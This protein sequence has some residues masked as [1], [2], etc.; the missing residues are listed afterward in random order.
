MEDFA[1]DVVERYHHGKYKTGKEGRR[2]GEKKRKKKSK[3]NRPIDVI[4]GFSLLCLCST[5]V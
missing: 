4:I 3:Y 2:K 5:V 1:S